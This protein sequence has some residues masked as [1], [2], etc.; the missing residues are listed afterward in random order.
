MTAFGSARNV[1]PRWL[2]GWSLAGA[3]AHLAGAVFHE[4]F[5]ESLES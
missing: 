1:T 2:T 3:G 5:V 4:Q